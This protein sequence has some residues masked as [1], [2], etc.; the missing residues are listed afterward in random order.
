MC[1]REGSDNREKIEIARSGMEM[2]RCHITKLADI[3]EIE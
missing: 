2:Y 1:R 3:T